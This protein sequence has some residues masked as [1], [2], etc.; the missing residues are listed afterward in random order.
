MSVFGHCISE[1]FQCE[2]TRGNMVAKFQYIKGHC[3]E[4]NNLVFSL[5]TLHRSRSNK[6]EQSLKL[7]IGGGGGNL[8]VHSLKDWNRLPGEIAGRL[9]PK[10][11]SKK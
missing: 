11:F 7:D 5:S 1:R 9:L 4:E 10:F 2:R 6:L 8:T 3:K